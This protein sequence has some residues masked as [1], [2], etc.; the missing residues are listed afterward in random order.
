MTWLLLWTVVSHVLDGVVSD[1]LWM[2]VSV[3]SSIGGS[4]NDQ[5]PSGANGK[6]IFLRKLSHPMPR[7][8]SYTDKDVCGALT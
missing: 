3:L 8:F 6:D 5:A 2:V 7:I 1:L 4:C